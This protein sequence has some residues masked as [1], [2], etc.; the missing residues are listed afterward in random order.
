MKTYKGQELIKAAK[1]LQKMGS[2]RSKIEQEFT[3]D[4]IDV[5]DREA[6]VHYLG[7]VEGEDAKLNV[8]VYKAKTYGNVYAAYLAGKRFEEQEYDK[9]YIWLHSIT[10]LDTEEAKTG[11]LQLLPEQWK[12]V[13]KDF[14][15]K[16]F[17]DFNI[18][19]NDQRWPECFVEFRYLRQGS[20]HDIDKEFG[21]ILL[22]YDP[23]L[24]DFKKSFNDYQF[25]VRIGISN[26]TTKLALGYYTHEYE[27]ELD[28]ALQAILP[29][30]K[31]GTT[32]ILSY[33]GCNGFHYVEGTYDEILEICKGF[34][35]RLF[36][37]YDT[38]IKNRGGNPNWRS[39]TTWGERGPV[40]PAN[41]EE[42]TKAKELL[43]AKEN[44]LKKASI[45]RVVNVAKRFY[46][47]NIVGL[48]KDSTIECNGYRFAD[49]VTIKVPYKFPKIK[50][51]KVVMQDKV[52]EIDLY[53]DDFPRS[54]GEGRYN[55]LTVTYS[56]PAIYGTMSGEYVTFDAALKHDSEK[57]MTLKATRKKGKVFCSEK[58][59]GGKTPVFTYIQNRIDDL[60]KYLKYKGFAP[61]A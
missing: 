32:P 10:K 39:A 23:A 60:E 46:N 1:Y 33:Y 3:L 7:K 41:S 20:G 43:N 34:R 31:E 11:K 48:F 45:E 57:R 14:M 36:E 19:K 5:E 8:T 16:F 18:D 22:E 51:S 61:K 49:S 53:R 12:Q 55:E 4:S 28:A 50:G 56:I 38:I 2:V 52:L 21:L 59:G 37:H 17:K 27:K 44:A 24:K 13:H 29:M 9:V 26:D 42:S 15:K 30:A 58:W 47:V 40:Y 35:E 25:E 54:Y 6:T